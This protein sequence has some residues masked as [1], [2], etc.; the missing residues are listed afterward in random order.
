MCLGLHLSVMSFQSLLSWETGF[1]G[2]TIKSMPPLPIINLKTDGKM[3]HVFA[4]TQEKTE[5]L[6][7]WKKTEWNTSDNTALKFFHK[8]CINYFFK[9][10]CPNLDRSILTVT[11]PGTHK[12]TNRG[13]VSSDS[14][15]MRNCRACF[16]LNR[17]QEYQFLFKVQQR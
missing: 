2:S 1:W 16:H 15:P 12:C 14:Y 11:N 3:L 17:W 13:A 10:V 6:C 8:C 9:C 4:C 7:V 5:Y